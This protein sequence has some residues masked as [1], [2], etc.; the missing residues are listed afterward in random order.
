MLRKKTFESEVGSLLTKWAK[1]F[2]TDFFRVRPFTSVYGNTSFVRDQIEFVRLYLGHMQLDGTTR[3]NL[4]RIK[5]FLSL[6]NALEEGKDMRLH[7]IGGS[8]VEVFLTVEDPM[9][10]DIAD[11]YGITE[12]EI[13]YIFK[14]KNRRWTPKSAKSFIDAVKDDLAFDGLDADL[15]YTFQKN[16]MTVECSI[17]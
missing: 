7:F 16:N 15:H 11:V 8:P 10:I 17:S 9:D 6:Q 12:F 3:E 13:I 4:E 2:R 5:R 14:G 1:D